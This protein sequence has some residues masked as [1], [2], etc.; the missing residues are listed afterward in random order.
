MKITAIR[1]YQIDLPVKE[2]SYKWSGGKS[3][4]V[5]DSTVVEVETDAGLKGYGEICTLGSAYLAAYPRGAR[6]GLFELAPS[7]LGSNPLEL[8]IL[9]RKMDAAMKG[10]PYVKSP[11]DIA[12]WDILG[13]ATGQAVATLLGG[14]VGEDHLLYRAI[15]QESPEVMAARV[16]EYRAEGYHRF[17]LKV[18][19][20]P[21]VD[22]ERIKAV[23]AILQP[24]DVLVADANTGWTQHEAV[25][26][27]AAIRDLD[28]YLEQPCLSYEECVAIRRLTPRPFILDEVIDGVD[29]VL[30]A[31]QD[32]S[33]DVINLKISKVGGL[34]KARQ[35]RDLCIS[36]GIALTIED[37]W[38]GDITTATIAHLAHSTPTQFLF[39]ATD[40]NS[41]GTKYFA[42]GAP[43]RVNGR[44][45]ASRDP[46][47]GVKPR[48]DLL[49]DPLLV[50]SAALRRYT[51]RTLD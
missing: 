42:D 6:T 17:Q 45:R 28:V 25:R 36:L 8:G 2:G 47:L 22:I 41:Y 18:G 50:V 29:M 31:A 49:G 32:R 24:G 46:G 9:N 26:V 33:A 19:G 12:C 35:I 51:E 27:A 20:D 43:R 5:F 7:L 4:D 16:S 14:H 23:R 13:Q 21:D 40:F 34:T 30:R 11:I 48:M 37:T 39:T 38:G 44:M 3:V 1:A 15:S 10:H